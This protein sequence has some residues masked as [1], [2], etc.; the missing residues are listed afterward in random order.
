MHQEVKAK[1]TRAFVHSLRSLSFQKFC[2]RG[3][4]RVFRRRNITC[5]HANYGGDLEALR[6]CKH[7]WWSPAQLYGYPLGYIG[8]ILQFFSKQQYVFIVIGS[9]TIHT[10]LAQGI[11]I[12]NLAIQLILSYVLKVIHVGFQWKFRDPDWSLQFKK[13]C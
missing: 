11:N 12:I 2:A 3:H 6:G 1:W 13:Y 10:K 8:D 4:E 7:Y 9:K 5:V